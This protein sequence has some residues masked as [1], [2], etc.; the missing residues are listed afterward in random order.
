MS[1]RLYLPT[2]RA[3]LGRL[4]ATGE[5]PE[6]ELAPEGPVQAEG[7]DEEA[8]Y[9]ALMTAAD[10]S[11]ALAATRAE[12]GL[13]RVVLV[14]EPGHPAGPV[15]LSDVVAVHL[16]TEDRDEAD[17]PDDDLAWF[18]PEELPHLI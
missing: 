18:A 13:R 16:D 4:V 8:E 2:T 15:R 17:D 9:A 12:A 10:L 5:L 11:T 14:A 6:D 3:G 1:G 7:E